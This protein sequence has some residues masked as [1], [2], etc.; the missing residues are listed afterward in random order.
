MNL[1]RVSVVL[2]SLL[3]ASFPAT[4][5]AGP[6]A[7]ASASWNGGVCSSGPWPFCD[8]PV[9]TVGGSETTAG[10]HA[11]AGVSLPSPGVGGAHSE[12]FA[13][14]GYVSASA[15]ANSGVLGFGVSSLWVSNTEASSGDRKSVV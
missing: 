7:V 14:Y 4:L 5:S 2:V 6:I 10:T 13:S 3:V 15:Y 11:S 1:T 12:A 9:I 8:G